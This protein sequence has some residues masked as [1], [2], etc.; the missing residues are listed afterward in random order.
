[1]AQDQLF[2]NNSAGTL[3]SGV[4]AAATS[5]P[6]S[7][8]AGAL[9]PVPSAPTFFMATIEKGSTSEQEIVRVTG[10][11]DADTFTVVRAQEGTTALDFDAG[12]V[13]GLRPTADA[14]NNLYTYIDDQVSELAGQMFGIGQTWQDMTASRALNTTYTNSTSRPIAVQILFD[15][16]EANEDG[17]LAVTPGQSLEA[18]R[19]AAASSSS[20]ATLLY[21]V[22][23]PGATYRLN[24][25]S[26]GAAALDSWFELRDV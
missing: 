22:V 1:M 12:D 19:Y 5:I 14:F 11:T 20:L 6:L 16:A 2:S 26:G 15:R 17:V 18:S 24:T 4:L 13:M 10:K 9:F 7:P 21:G 3:A 23:Q 25:A 8:G